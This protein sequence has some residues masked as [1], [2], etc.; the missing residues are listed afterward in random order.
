MRL[1]K[2]VSFIFCLFSGLIFIGCVNTGVIELSENNY[3]IKNTDKA[4]IFGDGSKLKPEVYAEAK[5]FAEQQNKVMKPISENY[6]P[7]APGR[8]ASFE[9]QFKLLEKSPLEFI[10]PSIP[11]SF[12]GFKHYLDG[13]LNKDDF[14]GIWE[15]DNGNITFGLINTSEDLR[16]KY[17]MFVIENKDNKEDEGLIKINFYDLSRN[18]I[19]KAKFTPKDYSI[20]DLICRTNPKLIDC[21][22]KEFNKNVTFVKIYPTDKHT[23]EKTVGVGTAW[24]ISKDGI[25]VTNAHV[26]KDAKKIFIGF[27]DNNPLEARVLMIDNRIDLAIVKINNKRDF[28]PLPINFNNSNNGTDIAVIGYPL[29]FTLGD[30]A[31]ITN[32]II[33]AQSGLDKDITRY[34]ITASIQ[35]GNSGG[36]IINMK[37][38]VVGIVVSKLS[39][40]SMQVVNFGIKSIYLNT[41]LEQLNIKTIQSNEQEINTEEIFKRYKNSVLP[42]WIEK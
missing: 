19:T 5:K 8:L 29:A 35:P 16:Y 37:G 21:D 6:I 27:R 39:D 38:E 11:S 40:T 3:Q 15:S 36:P 1:K 23:S 41:L 33:S 20:V 26:I 30:D 10:N 24:A 25:F 9:L 18:D 14:E 17:K 31:R 12:I 4:G 22:S 28:L 13:K 2:L 34:Q 32:G 42:I 7:V